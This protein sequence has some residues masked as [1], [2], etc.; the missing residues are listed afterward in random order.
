MNRYTFDM[1]LNIICR[2]TKAFEI[3]TTRCL[4]PYKNSMNV[5]CICYSNEKY[6][7]ESFQ[8]VAAPQFT[9]VRL[10]LAEGAVQ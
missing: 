1:N 7:E 8:T 3:S 10:S 4:Y 2:G 6:S 9:K 5:V